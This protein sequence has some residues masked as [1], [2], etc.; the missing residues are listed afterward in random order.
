MKDNS[1]H[2]NNVTQEESSW[3]MRHWGCAPVCWATSSG[4]WEGMAPTGALPQPGANAVAHHQVFAL[5]WHANYER[6][7]M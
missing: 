4:V 6:T 5:E 2:Y 3:Q 1:P 7:R